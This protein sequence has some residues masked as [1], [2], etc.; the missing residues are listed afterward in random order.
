MSKGWKPKNWEEV[1][2]RNAGRRK[3]HIRKR[4]QRAIRILRLL[5][6]I[7]EVEELKI[8]SYGWLPVICEKWNVSLATAS[9]DLTLCRQIRLQFL[10]MFGREFNCKRDRVI[11]TWD[12]SHY[13]FKTD[14]TLRAGYTTSVGH[15][16]FSSRQLEILEEDYAGFIFGL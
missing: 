4:K 11:W 7:N 10:K 13:G 6:L 16:H 9:R 15:F 12:W 3:L 5:A 8:N 2:K 14:E 1:C